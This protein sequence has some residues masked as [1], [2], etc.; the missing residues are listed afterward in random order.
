LVL[1]GAAEARGVEVDSADV[2]GAK[3][4]IR[5]EREERG[6]KSEEEGDDEELE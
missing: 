2:R 6:K 4:E 3:R 1:V 5:G